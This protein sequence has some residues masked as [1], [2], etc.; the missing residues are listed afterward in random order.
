M[1]APDTSDE[2]LA[3][4][5]PALCPL[6]LRWMSPHARMGRFGI[7]PNPPTVSTWRCSVVGVGESHKG[8]GRR[9]MCISAGI[10]IPLGIGTAGWT[11][12]IQHLCHSVHVTDFPPI[13][14][15]E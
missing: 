13:S 8:G 10:T 6:F 5:L 3:A 15:G 7:N 9:P 2:R 12:Y 1:I 4:R 14:P 11:P